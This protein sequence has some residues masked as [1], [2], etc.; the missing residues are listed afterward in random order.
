MALVQEADMKRFW[1]LKAQED[2]FYFVDSRQ[3]YRKTDLE[4]FWSAGEAGLD[5]ALELVDV[6]VQPTDTVVEIGCGVGRLT[7]VLARRG[8]RVL[9]IDISE[10][11]LD[12]AREL[13]PELDNV[14]WLQGDGA[15]LTGIDDASA[16][17]CVSIVVFQHIPDPAITLGYIREIGRVLRPGGWAAIHVSTDPAVHSRRPSLKDR[18][19]AL[20]GRAPRGRTNPAWM[21][22][23]VE[24]DDVREAAG[25][26]GLGIEK[27]WGAGTQYCML[28]LRRA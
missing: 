14:D 6:E 10:A 11:M 3:E 4:Q 27:V 21:G 25:E 17:A 1:D 8:A 24:L 19:R 22:S 18:L 26:S 7:R 28:R 13:N 9:A 16:D 20:V 15:S 12:R 23:A 5:Y 2:A